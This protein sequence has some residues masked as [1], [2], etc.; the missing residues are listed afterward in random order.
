MG[1]YPF[2]ARIQSLGKIIIGD[3]L[4]WQVTAGT[5]YTCCHAFFLINKIIAEHYIKTQS[6]T[7]LK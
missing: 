5:E 6:Y 3:D 7:Q 4:G 1:E 2:V